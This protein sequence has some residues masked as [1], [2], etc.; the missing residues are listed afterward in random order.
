MM[1]TSSQLHWSMGP[2]LQDELTLPV[3]GE[4]VQED[5]LIVISQQNV[6]VSSLELLHR[7]SEGAQKN[8][9][10]MLMTCCDNRREEFILAVTENT[11][12]L[13]L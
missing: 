6:A 12:Y 1:F 3:P 9:E 4:L 5:T 7:V 2:G 10:R 13:I 11:S 8:A